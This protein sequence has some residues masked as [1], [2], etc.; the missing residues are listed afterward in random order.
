MQVFNTLGRRKEE[1]IP[2]RPGE[3]SMYVCGATVQSDPHLGHGRSAVAFDAIRRYLEWRGYDVVYVRNITDV[4]DKIIAAAAEQGITVPELARIVAGKF[5]EA[6][7]AL[8]IKPATI[9]PRATDH[10]S[11]M[12][13]LIETLIEKGLAYP[14]GG[15]VY[16]AVRSLP[17][18]GKLSGRNLDDL[19]VGARVAAGEHKRDPLDFALWKAAKPGEPA[20]DSP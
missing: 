16:F 11:H 12:V 17:G 5:D 20:W 19:L 8:N 7:T 1:L 13:T 9:A 4:E 3:I 6:Y 10:I 2:R 14:A 15:D 18:Y